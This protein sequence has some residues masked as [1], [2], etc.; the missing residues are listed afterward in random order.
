M[1]VIINYFAVKYCIQFL[2]PL[3]LKLLLI[4]ENLFIIH[5]NIRYYMDSL[6]RSALSKTNTHI[7]KIK[8]H[9]N[10][11]I[12]EINNDQNNDQKS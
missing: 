2:Y 7:N 5:N 4:I 12:A 3:V 8:I 1:Y 11:M 9:I 6:Y 10:T